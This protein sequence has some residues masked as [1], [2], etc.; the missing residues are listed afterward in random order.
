MVDIEKI[1]KRTVQSFY[2]DGLIEIAIGLIFLLLGGV[3][4]R[5]DSRAR[6]IPARSGPGRSVLSSSS[7]RPASSSTGSPASLSAA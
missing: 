2:D 5:P 4:L 3:I 6:E 1:E 7:S